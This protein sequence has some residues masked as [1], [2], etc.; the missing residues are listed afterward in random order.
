MGGKHGAGRRGHFNDQ[1]RMRRD[2]TSCGQGDLGVRVALSRTAGAR[3]GGVRDWERRSS[4]AGAGRLELAGGVEIEPIGRADD[5]SG[6]GVPGGGQKAESG[7]EET[8]KRPK[9]G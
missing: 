3:C 8:V 2:A 4:R 1:G 5:A 6:R 7:D 9:S